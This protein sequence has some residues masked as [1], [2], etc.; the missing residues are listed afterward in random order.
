MSIVIERS[1][2]SIKTKK[3]K[4]TRRACVGWERCRERPAK[5]DGDPPRDPV[6]EESLIAH[7]YLLSNKDSGTKSLGLVLRVA[8]WAASVVLSPFAGAE[9]FLA[10]VAVVYLGDGDS[11]G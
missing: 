8:I 6:L 10:S 4:D 5:A 9:R 11:A 3:F 7:Q 1:T 2:T